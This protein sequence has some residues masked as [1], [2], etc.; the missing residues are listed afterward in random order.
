MI[1]PLMS[2]PQGVMPCISDCTLYLNGE[3]AI[4]KIAQALQKTRSFEPNGN[5]LDSKRDT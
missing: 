3:C 4:S 2:G 1:C 5:V